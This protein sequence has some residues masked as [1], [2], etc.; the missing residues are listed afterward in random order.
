MLVY[1][2]ISFEKNVGTGN[3]IEILHRI[4]RCVQAIVENGD[5]ILIFPEGR[6]GT[7]KGQLL[8]LKN[9][10]AIYAL[11][12][13]LPIVPIAITGT[14]NLDL[15]KELTIRFGEPLHSLPSKRPKAQEV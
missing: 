2:F 3:S 15:G 1:F 8:P 14:Q 7:I 13:G 5:G 4:D 12:S 10:V 11:G 6:L 9:G